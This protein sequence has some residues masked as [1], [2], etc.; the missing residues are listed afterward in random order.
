MAKIFITGSADGL[1]LFAATA[2]INQGH[3]V[4][5]HARNEHRAAEAKTKAPGAESILVA[6][7]SS[8]EETKKLATAVNEL[9]K[10]DAIIHNAAVYQ[11]PRNELS[12]DGLPLL[13]TVNTISPYILTCLIRKPER[14]IY[15]SSGMHLQGDPTLKRLVGD[16]TN[17]TYSDTKLHDLILAKAVARKC[18][19]V[20][21]AAVNPGWVP[22]KMGGAGAPDDLEKG[23]ETQAWL[24]VS[25]EAA[26]L[27]NGGYFHH[28]R[29]EKYLKEADDAKVQERF[30]EICA[31][32]SG[33][34]FSNKQD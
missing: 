2:L 3:Q 15:M 31:E 18:Q 6:D 17:I 33:V 14:L 9:G 34:S 28:K 1:G 8:I 24:A 10:F 13:L 5:L 19:G 30:F 20:F 25:T 32:I 21:S 12:V 29:P 4:V 16:K 27:A 23:F 22:T 26:A 7:L 11:V